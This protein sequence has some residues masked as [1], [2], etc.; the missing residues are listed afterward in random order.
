MTRK[1][2]TVLATGA[3]SLWLLA[4][5]VT[6]IVIN[7]DDL[8]RFD[9]RTVTVKS[10]APVQVTLHNTG[11]LKNH[12]HNFVLLKP[13]AEMG[14][15]GRSDQSSISDSFLH[16]VAIAWTP[17]ATAGA[18]TNVRFTAPAPGTYT[19]VCSWPGHQSMSKGTL[20]VE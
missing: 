13:G 4:A 12:G 15:F 14:N 18:T 5:Q 20:V 1:I 2:W 3:V 9:V 6:E 17:V 7:A 8:L 16:E 19:F 10:G 11:H